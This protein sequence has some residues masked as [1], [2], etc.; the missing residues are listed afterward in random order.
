MTAHIDCPLVGDPEHVCRNRDGRQRE[1]DGQ[2][3]MRPGS[4]CFEGDIYAMTVEA[5]AR[6]ASIAVLTAARGLL[7]VMAEYNGMGGD[8]EI[9]AQVL[10]DATG[11]AGFA[12]SLAWPT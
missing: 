7:A 10:A 12:Y 3:A 2:P 11:V 5:Q 9:E 6:Q 1:G 4:R 8:W